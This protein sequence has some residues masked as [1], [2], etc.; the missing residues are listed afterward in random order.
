[1]LINQ[2]RNRERPGDEASGFSLLEVIV[3]LVLMSAVMV[4]MFQ[5]QARLSLSSRDAFE[6]G[7]V[8]AALEDVASHMEGLNPAVTPTGQL[9]LAET[10]FSWEATEIARHVRRATFL[11]GQGSTIILYKVD[12]RLTRPGGGILHQGSTSIIGWR[13]SA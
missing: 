6:Q 1:M 2:V 13:A 7:I 8:T 12:F 5:L 4:P 9:R 11:Q 10:D 3:V